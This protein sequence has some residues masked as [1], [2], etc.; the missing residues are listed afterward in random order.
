MNLTLQMPQVDIKIL[1]KI[2]SI[3]VI[4]TCY[5]FKKIQ[6][7]YCCEYIF[8]LKDGS[9]VMGSQSASLQVDHKLGILEQKLVGA[10]NVFLILKKA[11]IFQQI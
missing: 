6:C 10:L 1:H 3:S 5:F 8:H 4:C 7:A 2:T 9:S 11:W